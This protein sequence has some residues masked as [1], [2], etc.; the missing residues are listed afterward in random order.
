MTTPRH[1]QYFLLYVVVIA[2]SYLAPFVSSVT[3]PLSIIIG[4]IVFFYLLM[5]AIYTYIIIDAYGNKYVKVTIT[6]LVMVTS[7]AM[8]Y[9]VAVRA[10]I[11]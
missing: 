7:Y 8:S 5:S 6:A 4:S 1:S 3:C 11:H 2:F 9:F 10:C